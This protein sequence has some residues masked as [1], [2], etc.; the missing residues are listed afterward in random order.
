M[1]ESQC[2]PAERR[3]SLISIRRLLVFVFL[4]VVV[5]MLLGLYARVDQV[6]A[7]LASVPIWVLPI[8]MVLSFLNYGIRYMKWQYYLH[9]IDVRLSHSDSLRVFLAGFTLTATPGKIGEAI[10][11]YFINDLNGTHVA[12]T[13]PLVVSERVTDLLAMVILALVGF[14][15]GAESTEQMETLM[16]LGG[17]VLVAAVILGRRELYDRLLKKLTSLG[18]LKRFSDSCDVIEDTMAR[19]LGPRPM[20]V[21]TAIS[22]PGWFMECLE[23]WLLLSILSGAGLP[24]LQISSLVL[25]LQATFIHCAASVIGA[26]TFMPG[27]LGT[28]ELTSML[29]MTK[30]IGL[31][32]PVAGAATILIRFVTLWFSVIVG[33]IALGLLSRRIRHVRT[34][35][36][37]P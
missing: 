28:Y 7:A 6:A 5:Y 16:L 32:D 24:S 3:S 4:G 9:R 34:D 8:M 15:L 33:F 1:T 31:S 29:L 12:R 17:I 10:K 14:G 13:A 2:A 30:L 20:F 27:G 35:K 26:V 18:P 25:L 37:Q 21:S 19:S 23:L 36:G 22:L 11:G